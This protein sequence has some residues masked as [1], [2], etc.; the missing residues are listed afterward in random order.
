MRLLPDFD[1]PIPEPEAASVR[2]DWPHCPVTVA[3]HHA[4]LNQLLAST[5]RYPGGSGRGVLYVGGGKYWPG[6]AVGIR[7]LREL[8]CNLPVEV[9]YRG[10]EEPV[11]A[12]DV[13]HLDGIT[14][15]DCKAMARE[16][17]DARILRGWE[18]KHYALTHTTLNTVLY[19]DAD[20]YCVADPTPLFELADKH[21]FVF[22]EDLPNTVHHVRWP[23]V[24]PDGDG[25]VPPIQG[26]QLC[27]NRD[28]CWD[29]LC[30]SHWMNQH[31]DFYYS[32]MFG[33]QDTWRIGHAAIGE[34]PLNLGM[35]PWRSVAFVCPVGGIDTVVHRCQGKMFR[36]EHV[37][38]HYAGVFAAPR[39][40]LPREERAFEH[41]AAVLKKPEDLDAAKA[42]RTIY[43]HKIW[44]GGSGHG[45][46][47]ETAKPYVEFIHAVAKIGGWKSCVDAG[48]GDGVI[49]RFLPFEDYTGVD[50]YPEVVEQNKRLQ[51][52]RKWI[53][54]DFFKD[55][56]QLPGGDV[57]LVKD[58]L[59]H[60]PNAW[61]SEWV[62]WVL[63]NPRW[64]WVLLTQ[65]VHQRFSGQDTYLGGYRA[66]HPDHAPMAD[67]TPTLRFEYGGQK[68]VYL[69][70]LRGQSVSK[71]SD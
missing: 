44:G 21:G 9:W 10:D 17:G 46:L 1:D 23:S 28:K 57:L 54:L 52:H 38:S 18:A 11:D 22:W 61:V 42:F 69:Y 16:R 20:A 41:F 37:P 26:G 29:L 64:K 39:W 63:A 34:K 2:P 49:A 68:M 60:W 59:H 71:G 43:E 70:D 65:D 32:H 14:F 66:L 12:G 47:G 4:A 19:L 35:A 48:C 51:P 27:L 15:H 6:I 24:W 7:L 45:S 31:S 36:H 40:E 62:R 30:I 67:F 3:R 5:Y 8:G 58:V 53:S 25:G 13:A 50:V 55:R 33:D 56:E